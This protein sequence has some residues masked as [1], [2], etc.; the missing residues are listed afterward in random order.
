MPRLIVILVGVVCLSCSS[1][2]PVE[3]KAEKAALGEQV[4]I[5]GDLY[6]RVMAKPTSQP[7][8]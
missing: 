2:V 1:K 7:S 4:A 6:Q 8:Q 3:P 5:N